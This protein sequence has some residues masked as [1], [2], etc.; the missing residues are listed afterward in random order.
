MSRG[1]EAARVL[2][3]CVAL[4]RRDALIYFSY[5]LRSLGQLGAIFMSL[6]LFFYVSKLVSPERFATPE[7]YFAFVVV[8]LAIVEVLTASLTTVPNTVKT[9]LMTGTFERM[10]V[11]PLGAVGGIVAMM[12]YPIALA[13]AT[14]AVLVLFAALAFGMPI[15]LSTVALALPAAVLGSL[16]FAPFALLFAAAVLLVK[17]A[18]SGA[19]FVVTGLSLLSGAFFPRELLPAWARWVSDI[20]PLS[21]AIELLRHLIVGTPSELS[22]W[23]CVERLVAFTV[24]GLP[25][26]FVAL[27]AS[28]DACRRRATLTEY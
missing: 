3:A 25:I 4:F 19:A 18:S 15:A 24:V 2:R 14:G 11:S 22:L 9:E 6:A 27:R 13:L 28:V 12:L 16:A 1:D 17:Q 8:G 5:R 10:A 26:A 20:Q 23:A 7:A 21:P